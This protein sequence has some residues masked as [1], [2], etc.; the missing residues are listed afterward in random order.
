MHYL[1]TSVAFN[2][3]VRGSV[4]LRTHLSSP[5]PPASVTIRYRRGY[6]DLGLF[7]ARADLI[8]AARNRWAAG[9]SGDLAKYRR[10]PLMRARYSVPINQI[11]QTSRPL[12]AVAVFSVRR[13]IVRPARFFPIVRESG[14]ASSRRGR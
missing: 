10:P 8:L 1:S 4:I 12:F 14:R 9:Q 7:I 3:R 13:L 11:N 6:V 5:S 2:P